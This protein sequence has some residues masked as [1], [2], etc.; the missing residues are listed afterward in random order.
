MK[1]DL[2]TEI[3]KLLTI[4]YKNRK[5]IKHIKVINLDNTYRIHFIIQL[6]P[7]D[8]RYSWSV[9]SKTISSWDIKYMLKSVFNI[10]VGYVT[11][12]NNFDEYKHWDDGIY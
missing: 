2:S 12:I 10:N 8:T 7:G 5:D 4:R 9:Y 1:K 3:H 11:V 6:E